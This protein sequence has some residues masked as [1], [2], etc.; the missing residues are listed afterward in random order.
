M[1]QRTDS[2][3]TALVIV[4]SFFVLSKL[5]P[6]RYVAKAPRIEAAI[7]LLASVRRRVL[8]SAADGTEVLR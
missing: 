7:D 1:E 4:I 2:V 5:A 6:Q 8:A 3:A